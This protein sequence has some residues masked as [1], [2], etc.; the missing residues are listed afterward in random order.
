MG[1]S[2]QSLIYETE[3]QKNKRLFEE[4]KNVHLGYY[5]KNRN[6]RLLYLF[7]K[8]DINYCDKN[9]ENL[10]HFFV[11]NPR[12]IFIKNE[13][14]KEVYVRDYF[15]QRLYDLGCDINKQNKDGIPP[16]CFTL[17]TPDFFIKNR[18][19]LTLRDNENHS[20]LYHLSK[21]YTYYIIKPVLDVY[22]EAIKYDE[23]PPEER[24]HKAIFFRHIHK[25]RQFLENDKTFID[26][27]IKLPRRSPVTPL[28]IACVNGFLDEFEVLLEHGVHIPRDFLLDFIIRIG[29]ENLDR[30]HIYKTITK[31]LIDNGANVNYH[32]LSKNDSGNTTVL[33]NCYTPIGSKMIRMFLEAGADVNIRNQYPGHTYYRPFNP[34]N[35]WCDADPLTHL[36]R[37]LPDIDVFRALFEYGVDPNRQNKHGCTALMG[38]F[39][40]ECMF[41]NKI[42]DILQLFLDN[43]ADLFLKNN[44]NMS[45][46]DHLC[47][48]ETIDNRLRV[49]IM[50]YLN[51]KL[52]LKIRMSKTPKFTDE[53]FL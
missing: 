29:Y 45:A 51:K 33:H 39:N 41:T 15:L 43:G 7:N 42:I 47:Y 4:I 31:K 53:V 24:L 35:I 37:Y 10:I 27:A 26:H 52:G 2:I 23:Y 46:L 22:P 20:V 14:G 38:L 36:T 50:N 18:A 48:C 12:G 34:E 6:E 21:N 16:I 30:L 3:E 19:D 11:K 1:N 49:S 17:N 40:T 9:G 44:S 13:T 8:I 28:K 5:G 32:D 25:V